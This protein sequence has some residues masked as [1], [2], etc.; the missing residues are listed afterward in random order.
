MAA[1]GRKKPVGGLNPSLND[2]VNYD[3]TKCYIY[4]TYLHCGREAERL[5]SSEALLTARRISF[6]PTT[7]EENISKI[8]G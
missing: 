4:R 3:R 6:I 2:D 5:L 1:T 7:R 8:P